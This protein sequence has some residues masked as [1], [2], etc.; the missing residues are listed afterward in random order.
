M[1][2]S[3]ERHIPG[4]QT[5]ALSLTL[6]WVE[7]EKRGGGGEGRVCVR[8]FFPILIKPQSYQIRGNHLHYLPKDLVS[9]YKYIE[10]SGFNIHFGWVEG[11]I[12]Q[13][14]AQGFPKFSFF[15]I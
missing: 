12:I 3:G 11:N 1:S 13:S 15:N 7:W 2:E 10:D 14:L 9:R 5:T 6:H 8:E 4:S